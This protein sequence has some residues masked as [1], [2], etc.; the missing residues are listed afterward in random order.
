MLV[1]FEIPTKLSPC[2]VITRFAIL[3]A[4]EY[5]PNTWQVYIENNLAMIRTEMTQG[6]T[7]EVSRLDQVMQQNKSHQAV[8]I[9]KQQTPSLFEQ[10]V[11]TGLK[12][13]VVNLLQGDYYVKPIRETG[14]AW[15][16]SWIISWCL[17]V[18]LML[19]VVLGRGITAVYLSRLLSAQQ[20]Q[21]AHIFYQTFFQK[22]IN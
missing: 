15:Y 19:V 14:D 2:S 10:I 13:P 21:I 8:A 18:A 4:I 12:K 6:F 11:K 9:N 5:I 17:V 3:F 16:Y 22:L 20:D 7:T 1:I